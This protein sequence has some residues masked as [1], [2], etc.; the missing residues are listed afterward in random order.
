MGA[1]IGIG[2]GRSTADIFRQTYQDPLQRDVAAIVD[3]LGVKRKAGTLSYDE[4]VT[5]QTKLEERIAAFE[6]DATMFEGL[7]GSNKTVVSQ[8]RTTL[9]GDPL[10]KRAKSGSIIASWRDTF[11][12][13][14]Q[15]LPKPPVTPGVAPPSEEAPTAATVLGGAPTPQRKRQPAERRTTILG[16]YGEGRQARKAALG[17]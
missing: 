3:P 4:V 10:G 6:K 2:G 16:G 5:A 15:V 17:Y 8:A 9:Y 14:L 11:M 13:D 12:R 1:T 7:G